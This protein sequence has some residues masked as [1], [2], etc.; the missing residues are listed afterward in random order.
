MMVFIY[1][2]FLFFYHL[3]VI[4]YAPFNKKASQW[5]AG[6]KGIVD[7]LKKEISIDDNI[8]W[9]HC[10][11]LGEFEQGR[12]IIERIKAD[13]PQYKILISFFLLPCS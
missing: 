9:F 4:V 1:D 13:F 12:P 11:S 8:V 10:A 3:A 7:K 2:I 6:R 5:V